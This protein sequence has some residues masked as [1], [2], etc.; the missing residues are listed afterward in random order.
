MQGVRE[1]VVE[2]AMQDAREEVVEARMVLTVVLYLQSHTPYV[3]VAELLEVVVL[4]V[5]V[6]EL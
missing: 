3:L 5:E 6:V 2:E 4:L 1:E